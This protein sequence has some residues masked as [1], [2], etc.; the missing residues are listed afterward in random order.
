MGISLKNLSSGKV[1]DV[2]KCV[3]AKRMVCIET[4]WSSSIFLINF[5]G[6]WYWTTSF[7]LPQTAKLLSC[8]SARV[9]LDG[10]WSIPV[11]S[12]ITSSES[13]QSGEFTYFSTLFSCYLLMNLSCLLQW[14]WNGR[15]LR[16]SRQCLHTVLRR[17]HLQGWRKKSQTILLMTHLL[18]LCLWKLLYSS[19]G[20]FVKSFSL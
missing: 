7:F 13:T 3:E 15:W 2:K 17:A 5:S 19:N 11:M 4:F 6:N 8:A 18:S 20:T 14:W 10:K 16:L 12:E 1:F 9:R